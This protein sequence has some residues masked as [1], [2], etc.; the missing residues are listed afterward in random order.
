MCITKETKQNTLNG[1]GIATL[2]APVSFCPKK[3]LPHLQPL[4]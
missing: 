1:V 2:S 3:Q 4:K